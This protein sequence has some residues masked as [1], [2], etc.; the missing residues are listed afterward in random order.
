METLRI[1][2]EERQNTPTWKITIGSSL[3]KYTE[4]LVNFKFTGTTLMN[5]VFWMLNEIYG[6][7]SS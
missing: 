5:I 3:I 7:N 4:C 6:C 1:I 2:R